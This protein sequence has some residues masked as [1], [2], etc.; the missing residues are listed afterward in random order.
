MST[1]QES[2]SVHLREIFSNEDSDIL[3]QCIYDCPQ[4]MFLD[5]GKYQSRF[6]R[7]KGWEWIT[8]EFHDRTAGRNNWT[9][10]QLKNRIKNYKQRYRKKRNEIDAFG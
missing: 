9:D 7:D 2:D 1:L 6:L 3:I 4:R 10:E 5:D 8:K